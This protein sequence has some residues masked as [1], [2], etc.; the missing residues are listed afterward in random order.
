MHRP[1]TL[2]PPA[3]GVSRHGADVTSLPG[4]GRHSAAKPVLATGHAQNA[5]VLEANDFTTFVRT[6]PKLLMFMAASREEETT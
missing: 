4:P 6:T 2:P 5:P 3:E 1:G